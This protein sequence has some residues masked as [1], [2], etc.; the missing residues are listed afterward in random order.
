MNQ[1]E[2]ASVIRMIYIKWKMYGIKM[3]KEIQ[4]YRDWTYVL[5]LIGSTVFFYWNEHETK[6]I[7]MKRTGIQ[8]KCLTSGNGVFVQLVYLYNEP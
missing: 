8:V 7:K 5:Q 4:W 1:C 6:I 3:V 2:I